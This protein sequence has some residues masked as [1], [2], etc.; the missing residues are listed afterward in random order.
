MDTAAASLGLGVIYFAGQQFI[1]KTN[2]SLV[3]DI[4]RKRRARKDE[5][6]QKQGRLEREL[7]EKLRALDTKSGESKEQEEQIE[8]ERAKI[9]KYEHLQHVADMKIVG[10]LG[11][12]GDGKSTVLN[13]LFGDDS[14]DGDQGPFR[15]ADDVNSVTKVVSHEMK[16]RV[17]YVDTPG[18][19]DPDGDA[20]DDE[21]F[22]NLG[23]YLYGCNGVNAF[24]LVMNGT[25]VRFGGNVQAMLEYYA[26]YFGAKQFWSHLVIVM[27]RI[28]GVEKRKFGRSKRGELYQQKMHEKFTEIDATHIIPIITVGFDDD[29]AQFRQAVMNAVDAITQ[30]FGKLQCEHIQSPIRRMEQELDDLN[31]EIE[32]LKVEIAG[33]QKDIDGISSAREEQEKRITNPTARDTFPLLLNRSARI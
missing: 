33:I 6:A 16:D 5:L 25:N 30:K 12:S 28:E 31:A 9:Q 10:V 11:H 14:E 3:Q 18:V 2:E 1:A 21:N 23:E 15:T 7:R 17:I 19:K 4:K 20:K 27:T 26:A 8:L 24:V 29:Y 22:N 13:R 32:E